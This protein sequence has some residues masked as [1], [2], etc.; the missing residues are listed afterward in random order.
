ME[1]NELEQKLMWA[2]KKLFI[3]IQEQTDLIEQSAQAEYAYRT[4]LASKMIE[5]KSDGV[6]VTIMADLARGDK[7]IAKLKLDRDIARGI[8]DA[9]RESIR[10]IQASGNKDAGENDSHRR[11]PEMAGNRRRINE[12]F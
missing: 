6:A 4:A 5:L 2:N 7:N 12:S 10:A 3:K 9:C 8:A 1:I 11:I